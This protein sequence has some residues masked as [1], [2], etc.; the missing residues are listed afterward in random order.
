M[1]VLLAVWAIIAEI[2]EVARPLLKVLRVL[3]SIGLPFGRHLDILKDGFDWTCRHARPA[4]NALF[5]VDVE[6]I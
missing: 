6:L 4:V 5:G 3:G 2:D 1:T